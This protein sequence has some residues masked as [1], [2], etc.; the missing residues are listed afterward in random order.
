MQ[1]GHFSHCRDSPCYGRNIFRG[2]LPM[3]P[4]MEIFL[5]RVP[6]ELV[7]G[8]RQ[9]L[10]GG[11]AIPRFVVAPT[12]QEG[13]AGKWPQVSGPL[14]SPTAALPA[15]WT[16]VGRRLSRQVSE[17]DF[18]ARRQR[19]TGAGLGGAARPAEKPRPDPLRSPQYLFGPLGCCRPRPGPLR[20]RP[21]RRV[22]RQQGAGLRARRRAS[23]P[24]AG[25]G[26]GIWALW[27]PRA[28]AQGRRAAEAGGR[29]TAKSVACSSH[30][31]RARLGFGEL[32]S[33][34][35]LVEKT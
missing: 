14:P 18:R 5:M 31:E 16:R 9:L 11:V 2:S 24:G 27:E 29:L 4:S 10:F 30:L 12:R 35:R 23:A 19:P 3:F 33:P 26:C 8:D 1:I 15:G 28:S 7:T 17:F 6:S 21:A 32:N 34:V 13:M 25:A 20:A 22:T